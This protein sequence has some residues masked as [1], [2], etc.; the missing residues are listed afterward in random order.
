MWHA[1]GCNP[2]VFTNCVLPPAGLYPEQA[3]GVHQRG[4]ITLY[5]VAD[6]FDRKKLDEVR[7]CRQGLAWIGWDWTASCNITT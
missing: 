1:L 6:S 3:R 2:H 4:R 5:C 7:N